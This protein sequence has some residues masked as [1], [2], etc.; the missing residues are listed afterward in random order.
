MKTN[1]FPKFKKVHEEL[2]VHETPLEEN[3]MILERLEAYKNS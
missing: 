1:S 3:K 2:I